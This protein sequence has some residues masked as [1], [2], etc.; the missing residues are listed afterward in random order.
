MTDFE[1][2]VLSDLHVLKCQMEQV[3]G[4]GQPGRL[5]Q[6]EGRVRCTEEAMQKMKGF[7]SAFGAVLGVMQ[8]IL[9]Y[10]GVRKY[11]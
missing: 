7:T 5:N 10:I 1:A 8:L 11:L 4:I 3:M 9:A 2:Q 6:L